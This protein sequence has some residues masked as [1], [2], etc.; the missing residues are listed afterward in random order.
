MKPAT[1]LLIP[2]WGL[3]YLRRL[4]SFGLA[5]L[6]SPGN[7][8][9]LAEVTELTLV[10]LTTGEGRY[11]LERQPIVRELGKSAAIDYIAID[12]LVAITRHYA[13]PLTWAYWRGIE[14]TGPAMTD[15]YFVFMNADFV[16]ADGSLRSLGRLIAEGH[17]SIL[18][19]NLRVNS[20]KAEADLL[21]H[22]DLDSGVMTVPPRDM[23]RLALRSPHA[24]QVAKTVNSGVSHSVMTNQLFWQADENTVISH[25]YLAFMLA[26][27]PERAVDNIQGFCDYAFASELCPTSPSLAL[28]DSDDFCMI[29][30]QNGLQEFTLLRIGRMSDDDLCHNVSSW[31]TAHHRRSAVAHQIVFH[32]GEISPQARAM[33]DEA[34]S[35]VA[36][37]D[38]K[39]SPDPLPGV[40]HPFWIQLLQALDAAPCRPLERKPPFPAVTW[41]ERIRR[42][43]AG[44]PL[45]LPSWHPEWLD[46]RAVADCLDTFRR[47]PQRGRLLYIHGKREALSEA[48]ATDIAFD[49]DILSTADACKTG[50]RL[51]DTIGEKR[52]LIVVEL[53]RDNMTYIN[54]MTDIFMPCLAPGGRIVFFLHDP[55]FWTSALALAY[56]MRYLLVDFGR[57]LPFRHEFR[58]A[59]GENR[60]LVLEIYRRLLGLMARRGPWRALLPA[61]LVMPVLAIVASRLNREALG[62]W[63]KGAARRDCS[64]FALTIY[65]PEPT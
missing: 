16:L 45:A 18:T 8:P 20:E 19:S 36:A 1:R 23:V 60:R 46:Y 26:L 65:G 25:H 33:A 53:D 39:L 48:L 32:A 49:T 59:S 22:L 35:F 64:S 42:S 17:R 31:T 11:Y 6:A 7:L 54:D 5:A 4:T 38:R 44:R 52:R 13:A 47:D 37:I 30:M 50:K 14:T 55:Y 24:T 27:R 9:A 61:L 57:I 63:E 34:R 12:D 40:N 10:F 28:D 29:E 51:V 62:A 58:L 15:T 43:I 56:D 2:I 41:A 3:S 21:R